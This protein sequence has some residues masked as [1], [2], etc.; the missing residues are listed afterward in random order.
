MKIEGDTIVMLITQ[1]RLIIFFSHNMSIDRE[2]F[3]LFQQIKYNFVICPEFELLTIYK[4][5][6]FFRQN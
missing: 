2:M 3:A 6:F 1:H 4:K 5:C